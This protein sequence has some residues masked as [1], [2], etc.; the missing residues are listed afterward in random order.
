[1]AICPIC[2]SISEQIEPGLRDGKT[3]RCPK[4]DEFDVT[5]TVLQSSDLMN[6]NATKWETALERA[7]E[8]ALPGKRPRIRT[9][10][11]LQ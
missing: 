2:K 7:R 9:N 3:Y 10:H 1:M 5:D 6:A 11:F 8:R 4:H